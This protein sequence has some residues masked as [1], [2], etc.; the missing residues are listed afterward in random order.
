MG[1]LFDP[2]DG[3]KIRHKKS[4]AKI[5]KNESFID[6]QKTKERIL[7]KLLILKSFNIFMHFCATLIF[8]KLHFIQ[9]G[10]GLFDL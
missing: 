1:N 4:L 6:E 3:G 9:P 5:A 8:F 2:D 7:T 10:S